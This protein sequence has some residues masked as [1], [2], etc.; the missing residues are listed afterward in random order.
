MSASN[1]LYRILLIDLDCTDTEPD[2]IM[3]LDIKSKH[4]SCRGVLIVLS[5]NLCENS[6]AVFT[7]SR[8]E[9]SRRRVNRAQNDTYTSLP[10]QFGPYFT[11]PFQKKNP[12]ARISCHFSSF[13]L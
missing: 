6:N 5:D 1:H 8:K 13:L 12:L 2:D 9:D 7:L 10:T 3:N 11:T 4:E